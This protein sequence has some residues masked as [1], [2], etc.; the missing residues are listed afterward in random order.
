M[1]KVQ[2]IKGHL[3]AWANTEGKE[4]GKEQIGV[5]RCIYVGYYLL[6]VIIMTT[7][8]QGV[9]NERGGE[10]RRQHPQMSHPCGCEGGRELI[11]IN[12]VIC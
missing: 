8:R 1:R 4:G 9:H 7:E 12:P 10:N 5:K 6:K 2:D 3:R 11:R